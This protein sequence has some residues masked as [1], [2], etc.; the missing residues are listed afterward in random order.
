MI[1]SAR[2][3]LMWGVSLV[4]SRAFAETLHTFSVGENWNPYNG[5]KPNLCAGFGI[6]KDVLRVY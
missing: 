5:T 2:G 3:S 4:L 6:T 1:M